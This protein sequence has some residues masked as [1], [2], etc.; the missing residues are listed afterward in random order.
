VTADLV[1][2]SG[3]YVRNL[4]KNTNFGIKVHFH[5]ISRDGRFVALT[6]TY[7]NTGRDGN[8]A[9]VPVVIIL[10]VKDGKIVREDWYYDNSLFY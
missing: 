2:N 9:S 6:G 1:R 5:F 8:L 10:E 7:T 3:A 4:F